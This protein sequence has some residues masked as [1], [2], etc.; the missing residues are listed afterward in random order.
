MRLLQVEHDVKFAYILEVLVQG[1]DQGM[2]KLK[3]GQFVDARSR[4]SNDEVETGVATVDDFVS[5]VLKEAALVL[6]SSKA[7][8]Y[9]FTLK[10]RPLFHRHV[11][12]ILGKSGLALLVDHQ[13]KLDRHFLQ[14]SDPSFKRISLNY[15]VHDHVNFNALLKMLQMVPY[16][17]N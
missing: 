10:R 11:G 9:E 12:I 6:S 17:K 4:K 2:Y 7:F 14:P 13:Q 15:L 1:L 3:T 5:L 16:V 8:P